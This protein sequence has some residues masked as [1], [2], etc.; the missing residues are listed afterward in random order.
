MRTVVIG[1]VLSLCNALI[2]FVH[3]RKK[4]KKGLSIDIVNRGYCVIL[5]EKVIKFNHVY[6]WV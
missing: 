4:Y 2:R 3:V 1:E 6:D 5:A